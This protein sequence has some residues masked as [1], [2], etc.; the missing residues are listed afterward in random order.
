MITRVF[1]A[2]RR[3]QNGSENYDHVKVYVSRNGSLYVKGHE[4]AHSAAWRA[5]VKEL[6]DADLTGRN[7]KECDD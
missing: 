7:K 4:L 2:L 1:D 3:K 5:K 6:I